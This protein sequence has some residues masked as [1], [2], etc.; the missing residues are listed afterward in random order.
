LYGYHPYIVCKE[1]Q[2]NRGLSHFYICNNSFQEFS[3]SGLQTELLRLGTYP[4]RRKL[5]ET[6]IPLFGW[7]A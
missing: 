7:Q 5:D 2:G 1:H 3:A 4:L 6:D